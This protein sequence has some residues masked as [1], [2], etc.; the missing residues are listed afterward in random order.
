[1]KRQR[2]D[3][4]A[5]KAAAVSQ[6][7]VKAPFPLQGMIMVITG[8]FE[9]IDRGD[10]RYPDD[11]NFELLVEKHGGSTGAVSAERRHTSS[12]ARGARPP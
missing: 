6:A 8:K 2:L 7:V 4:E 12:S 3:F 10:S 5:E 1:M 9:C 11:K